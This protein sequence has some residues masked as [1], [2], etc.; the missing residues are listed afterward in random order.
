MKDFSG[1]A[2]PAE[3]VARECAFAIATSGHVDVN[4]NNRTHRPRAIIEC[5]FGVGTLGAL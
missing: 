4:E 1:F 5:V 2:I 3:A